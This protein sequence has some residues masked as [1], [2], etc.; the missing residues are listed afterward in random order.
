MKIP[1]N[2]RGHELVKALSVLGYTVVRQTG[3]HIRIKTTMNGDHA[4]TIPNHDPIKIGTLN[5]ILN[6][7]A[8][9]FEITK[10]DLVNRLF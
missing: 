4:E 6:N 7:I 1:R 9:H 2:I 8:E 3:S 10:E 5:K